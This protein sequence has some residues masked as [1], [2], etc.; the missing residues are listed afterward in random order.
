MSA[1][2][3]HLTHLAERQHGLVTRR[4]A[5]DAGLGRDAW[6]HRL[7]RGDWELLTPRVA[8]R[9]G[10]PSTQPQRALAAV[11]DVGPSAYVSHGAGVAL[12]GRAPGSGS[13]P[14]RSWCCGT[15]ARRAHLAVVHHPRHLPDPFAAVLDGVPVARPALLLLQVAPRIHPDRLARLLDWFWTRRLLSGPSV[16]AELAPLMHRGRPGTA[17][18]R[19]L[20]D[21]LPADYVPPASALEGRVAQILADA[22]L[23]RWRRQVDLG[24]ERWCGRVDLL[25]EALPLV[26]EVNSEAHHTALTDVE[27]DAERRRRLEAAG[28]TVV[29]VW[30]VEV[31]HAPRVVVDRVR[32]ARRAVRAGLAA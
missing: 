24:G 30:D 27:A 10:S 26:V 18:L 11:L 1:I 29:E 20:L 19:E 6:R 25:D 16:R 22:G 17:P 14:A 15:A 31:W 12:C 8:R 4:Q 28:F 23:G 21:N 13:S 9:T 3:D 2:D 7:R 5:R 32:A